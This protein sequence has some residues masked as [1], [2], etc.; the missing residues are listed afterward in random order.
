M[1]TATAPNTKHDNSGGLW[2][3]NRAWSGKAQIAGA[4]YASICVATGLKG[5]K[6]PSHRLHLY[7]GQ[8]VFSAS[9]WRPK[10][11]KKYVASGHV[12]V[13]SIEWL[14]FVFKNDSDNDRAP[15]FQLSFLAKE[16]DRKAPQGERQSEPSNNSS[17]DQEEPPF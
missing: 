9:L 13:G 1:T 4:T 17:P 5:E 10:E 11:P 14:V 6:Q 8:D 12:E 2:H 16:G 15:A 3:E 7:R